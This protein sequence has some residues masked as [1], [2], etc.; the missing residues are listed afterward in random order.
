MGERPPATAAQMVQNAIS[1]LRRSLALDGRL[2]TL[3][4][5]YRLRVADGERDVDRFEALAA[6][7]RELLER[8]PAAAAAAL[9]EALGLWQGDPLTDLAYEG[10]AQPEIR[11]LEEARRRPSRRA[12]TPISR[13]AATPRSCRSWRPPSPPS[14]CANACMRS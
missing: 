8:D 5:A 10:F 2:E 3:G 1:T 9:R 14:R 13:S 6:R 12:S 11:R 7:G 4:S